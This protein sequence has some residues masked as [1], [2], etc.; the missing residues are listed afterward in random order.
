MSSVVAADT[1]PLRYLAEIGHADLL[2][3]LFDTVL[4]PPAVFQE[5]RNPATPAVVRQWIETKRTWLETRPIRQMQIIP[6][7]DP[8]E[9]EA[10]CLALENNAGAVLLDERRGRKVARALGLPVAGT[11]GV[12]ELAAERGLVEFAVAIERL[13][14]TS[15]FLAPAIIAGALERDRVRREQQPSQESRPD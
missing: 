14:R 2:G 3:Q 13:R 5:L 8:G 6:S 12:L 11:L 9:N 7:L 10:I 4:I 1:G 15:I